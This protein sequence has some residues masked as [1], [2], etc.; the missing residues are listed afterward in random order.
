MSTYNVLL[1]EDETPSRMLF[2][3]LIG[4][5]NDIFTLVGEAEDGR[6]GLELFLS[7]R[8]HLLV[9]D[10]TM[11]G[12][13]GLDMLQKIKQS[14]VP[15]PQTIILTCHQDFHFAQQA[16]QLGA[17]SYLLKDDCLSDT[18]L[19]TRTMEELARRIEYQNEMLQKTVQL[20]QKLRLSEL[21]IDR[22]LFFNMLKSSAAETEWLRMLETSGIPV[23][24]GEC[25][26]LLIELDRSSLR[27]SVNQ[28]EELKLWQFAGIN[29][30][31]ELLNG[32]GPNKVI[33]LDRGRFFAV[34]AARREIT[35][36]ND[37]IIQA[38]ATYLKMNCFVL[39]CSFPQGIV[40]HMALVK[41]GMAAPYPFFFIHNRVIRPEQLER[42][43]GFSPIP[44]PFGRYWV[45][46]FRQSLPDPRTIS[47]SAEE[48]DS[49]NKQAMEQH[50]DPDQ[51][52]SLILR[53]CIEVNRFPSGS[54][55]HTEHTDP[56][57][58]LRNDLTQ[59]QTLVS[60]YDVAVSYFRKLQ[61]LQDDSKK[62]DA[63]ILKMIQ[64][65]QED[66]SSPYKLEE[67]AASIHYS[68]PYFS[69][70]FKK[71]TGEGF[72]QY[73]TRL[74]M[75][76]AKMLLLT[77]DQKTAEIAES[78]GL[79]NY[80]SFNRLFKKMT[81]LTPSEFRGKMNDVWLYEK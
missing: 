79:E 75:E 9:A 4:L 80:R 71:T 69:T 10:I 64:M 46:V 37:T 8:P 54:S 57:A 77:T 63:S 56:E 53:S 3:H 18:E 1:V 62:I 21:E 78:V 27:F 70:M 15:M 30:L 16:I 11:P 5:R 51:I 67:L 48:R 68:V 44:K 47:E 65:M 74:R 28:T 60:V 17:A 72:I 81:G 38:F 23:A 14:G 22:S 19:L 24:E 39:Q 61:H 43:N 49:F 55:D 50:W 45:K 35:K 2:R 33:A 40:T 58:V 31:T 76:K 42:L 59:C 73:L 26:V 13:S 6:E 25:H 36:L 41:K 34:F 66:V 52:K 32:L 12:M 29:V 20:E 7:H